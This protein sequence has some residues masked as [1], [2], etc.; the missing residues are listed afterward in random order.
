MTQRN[1]IPE[2]ADL[3]SR[4]SRPGWFRRWRCL[5]ILAMKGW[6]ASFQRTRSARSIY[7]RSDVRN[8]AACIVIVAAARLGGILANATQPAHFLEDDLGFR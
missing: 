6:S 7:S 4:S 8:S 2:L 1:E 5:A 3:R